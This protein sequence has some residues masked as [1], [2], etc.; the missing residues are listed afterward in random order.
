LNQVFS[1]IVE[2]PSGLLRLIASPIEP[3]F[4]PVA[5]WIDKGEYWLAKFQKPLF[6]I[7][8]GIIGVLVL[9]RCVALRADFPVEGGRRFINDGFLFSDEGWYSTSVRRWFDTGQW[10]IAGDNNT[11]L[12]LPFHQVAHAVSFLFFGPTI[13]GARMTSAMGFVLTCLFTFLLLRRLGQPVWV[14][15]AAVTVMASN[16][17][18]FIHSRL[19]I[20]ELPMMMFVMAAAWLATYA[21]G[22]RAWWIA[23][24]VGVVFLMGMLTKSPATVLGPVFALGIFMLNFTRDRKTWPV[25]FGAPIAFGVVALGGFLAWQAYIRATFPEDVAFFNATNIGTRS[26]I[27]WYHTY[28]HSVWFHTNLLYVDRYLYQYLVYAVPWLLLLA[29]RFHRK[30]LVWLSIMTILIWFALWAYFGNRQLRY[31]APMAAPAG[32]LVA[33][34]LAAMWEGRRATPLSRI[35]ALAMVIL[36]FLLVVRGIISIGNYMTNLEYS[37]SERAREIRQLMEERDAPNNVL[38]SHISCAFALYEDFTSLNDYYAAGPLDERLARFQPRVFLTEYPFREPDQET[39]EREARSGEPR[40]SLARWEAINKYYTVE[41]LG[42]V[43]LLQNTANR[44]V[45][46][47]WLEPRPEWGWGSE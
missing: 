15:M 3:F 44:D 42:P 16:F 17:Y 28:R 11:G 1:R 4:A 41:H 32:I 8:W 29:P 25:A 45:Q 43:D 39:I 47:Y 9:L 2:A 30:P 14:G 21:K 27:N 7:W 13:E 33:M 26:G 36:M 31:F 23:P 38:L 12:N 24:I 19:A 20:G 6:G 5:R 46:L 18:F 10:Y 35:P 34:A 40:D 22:Q 37:Y